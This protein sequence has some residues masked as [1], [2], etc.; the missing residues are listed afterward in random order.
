M[1][2]KQRLGT[3]DFKSKLC[4]LSLNNFTGIAFYFQSVL[5]IAQD[6]LYIGKIVKDTRSAASLLEG[7][8]PQGDLLITAVKS[9]NVNVVIELMKR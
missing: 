8:T 5:N 6:L 2:R 4:K 3:L 9:S 7:L 1:Q